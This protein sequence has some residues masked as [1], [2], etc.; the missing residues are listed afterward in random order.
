MISNPSF[1]WKTLV[2]TEKIVLCLLVLVPLVF[3]PLRRP[4]LWMSLLPAAPFTL[5]TTGYGPTVEISFQYIL[6]YV[7]FM[8]LATALAL[9]AFGGTPQGRA[10][11]AGAIGG[12]AIA[13]FLTA[14]IWGAMPP[15]DKF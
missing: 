10:R 8:F 3:L 1:V 11:L 13:T 2:T 6:L 14:R 15:G 7:P 5:L 4:F 9:A 12:I